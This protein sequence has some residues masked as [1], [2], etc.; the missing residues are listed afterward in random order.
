MRAGSTSPGDRRDPH[1][2]GHG[3]PAAQRPVRPEA[4]SPVLGDDD[5]G[6]PD[7]HAG[8]EEGGASAAA[9]AA[10]DDVE[11]PDREDRGEGDFARLRP[12][13][14]VEVRG[15]GHGMAAGEQ[16]EEEEGR[17]AVGVKG[18]E[19]VSKAERD[20]HESNQHCPYR[21]WCDVCVRARGRRAAHYRR[22]EEKDGNI[23]KVPRISM[24][25]MFMSKDDEDAGRNPVFVMAD[26]ATGNKFSRLV[27]QKGVG[28]HGQMDW[29]ILESCMELKSWGH[30]GGEGGHIVLKSDG[31]YP[32]VALRE[33]ISHHHG[34]QVVPEVSAKGESPSNG[35]IE[36]SVQ[37][38]Q[39]FARVIKLS[40]E[41]N[42]DITIGPD[43]EVYSWLIRWAGMLVSRFLMG[44]DGRTAYER[45]KGRPCRILT[46]PFG[47]LVIYKEIRDGKARKNKLDT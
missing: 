38:V 22:K 25:Y 35:V 1:H 3:Q 21:S 42:V 2:H 23:D 26:E 33:A 24:D 46:V 41:S 44:P 37:I 11:E 19:R 28:Q 4:L 7:V 29:L 17:K 20:E 27:A 31:E 12:G 34:G 10:E 9:A 45:L 43:L 15:L 47:E 8:G 13:R 40:I 6:G 36:Q 5:H 16:E 18:P 32:I 30:A 14:G 39:E